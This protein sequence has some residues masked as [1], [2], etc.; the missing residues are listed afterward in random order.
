MFPE[1]AARSA[2]VGDLAKA[3]SGAQLIGDGT[4]KVTGIHY[5]TKWLAPGHLFAA[6]RGADTD[7]HRYVESALAQG[8]VALLVEQP[9]AVDVPQ[10]VVDNSR[11]A[12]ASLSTTFFA[13]P[14]RDLEVTGIT[15]TDGK[16]TTSYILDHVLTTAGLRTGM[17][18]TVG[19][20]V[21]E[22]ANGE[23]IVRSMGHQTTPESNLL[24]GYL[25]EMTERNVS[26]AIV[27]A[28]SHGIAMYR[29]D[30]LRFRHA[31]VT[32]MTHEHLEFHGTVENY[33]RTKGVLVERVA[34]EGGV[35]VLNSDDPGAMSAEPLAKGATLVLTSSNG[36]P[37]AELR[38][39]DA[40]IRA[41]GTTF[42]LHA[43][44]HT[45]PVALPLIGGF[46]IDNALIAIGL[47]QA[48]GVDL[49]RI[50]AALATTGGVKGRMKL[51]DEGQDFTVVVDFAHTPESLR[52]ILQFLRTMVT[53]RIIVV[54]G[55]G[56]QRDVTKR[57]MQGAV[58][59][60]LAEIAIFTNEDPRHENPQVILND[61]AAGATEHGAR[62]G[63]QFHIV[64]DRTEAIERAFA[65]AEPGDLV[66]LAGKGHE[67]TID[68]GTYSVTWDEESIART[69]LRDR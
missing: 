65:L 13:D 57:P 64:A 54:T 22:A 66:L 46:N 5:N 8:A 44:S 53:G 7:G 29:L 12:L 14:S 15:G 25:R 11:R 38:A 19:I 4:V 49:D 30:H 40:D 50:V 28:T 37:N 52:K 56:G 41:D 34:A 61:I 21:G 20:K 59:V 47:A 33:W 2:S 32:N 39:S 67:D 27:E 51:V 36:N 6:L 16:T 17:I 23:T 35:V 60:E 62:E 48:N 69:L 10:I 3:I 9:L 1:Y 58:C 63:E 26:H 42:T 45:F 24:Q 68:F 31:G 55:S 18:G 43:G